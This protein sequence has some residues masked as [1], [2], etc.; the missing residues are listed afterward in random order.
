MTDFMIYLLPIVFLLIVGC[1]Q[2]TSQ[3]LRGRELYWTYQ[4]NGINGWDATEGATLHNEENIL[5][6]ARMLGIDKV[7][8][9]VYL[10]DYRKFGPPSDR[11]EMIWDSILQ[12]FTSE[13]CEIVVKEDDGEWRQPDSVTAIDNIP[14][15]DT[16]RSKR[17]GYHQARSSAA[18]FDDLPLLLRRGGVTHSFHFPSFRGHDVYFHVRYRFRRQNGMTDSVARRLHY[19]WRLTPTGG[20]L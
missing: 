14:Y 20:I 13:S 12:V 2:R 4:Y 18:R 1:T 9:S 16:L 7:S 11:N 3:D 10:A 6:S 17:L 15:F 5:V 19:Q 8:F